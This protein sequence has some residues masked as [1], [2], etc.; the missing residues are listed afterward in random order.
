MSEKP[1]KPQVR[2]E[3]RCDQIL[4]AATTCFRQYGFHKASMSIIAKEASMSV[5]HIYHYFEN[6][7]SIITAISEKDQAK[8]N[9]MFAKFIAAED[10]LES[11]LDH[12]DEGMNDCTNREQTTLMLEV[13]AEASRNISLHQIL[14]KFDEEIRDQLTEIIAKS[15]AANH[16]PSK[17]KEELK[18]KANMMMAMFEGIMLRSHM[19]PEMNPHLLIGELR[20]LIKALI[21]T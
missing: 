5:G 19:N 17:S 20:T 10:P 8:H 16:L 1:A 13:W 2:N 6:K 14:S 3:Q 15:I 4:T 11:M 9:E 21:L 12:L 7:E 18:T